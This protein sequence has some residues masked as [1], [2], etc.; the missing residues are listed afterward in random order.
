M[1][2]VLTEG[3]RKNTPIEPKGDPGRVKKRTGYPPARLCPGVIHFTARSSTEREYPQPLRWLK[4]SLI[5]ETSAV[6]S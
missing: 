4:A 2:R 3:T 5:S 6:E 1:D